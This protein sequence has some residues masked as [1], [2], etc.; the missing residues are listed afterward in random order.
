MRRT[1][2]GGLVG[3][4]GNCLLTERIHVLLMS[5]IAFYQRNLNSSAIIRMTTSPA[6]NASE[7]LFVSVFL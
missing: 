5:S 7:S 2:I 1:G 6:I 4:T 3:S